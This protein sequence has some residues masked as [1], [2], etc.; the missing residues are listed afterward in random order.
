MVLHSGFQKNSITLLCG[1]LPNREQNERKTTQNAL[2][3]DNGAE[4][5]LCAIV[6][7]SELLA[8]P[9]PVF[10]EIYSEI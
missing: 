4:C 2:A 7:C 1:Q 9:S 6:I 8:I 10:V 3:S 5:R